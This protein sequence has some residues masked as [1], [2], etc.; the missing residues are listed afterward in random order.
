VEVMIKEGDVVGSVI[1]SYLLEKTRVVG[2]SANERNYHSFYQLLSGFADVYE[3]YEPQESP[4]E[5]LDAEYDAAAFPWETFV[6]ENGF[7]TFP[8]LSNGDRR[9]PGVD[10]GAD[11]YQLVVALKMFMPDTRIRQIMRLLTAVL[12]IGTIEFDV[13]STG[14]ASVKDTGPS[15][16]LSHT[17]ALLGV[18]TDSFSFA[19]CNRQIQTGSRASIATK[20]LGKTIPS[21]SCLWLRCDSYNENQSTVIK[22]FKMYQ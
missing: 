14:H 22:T 4:R 2:Q 11:L 9:V 5:D 19:I 15:G 17:C 7:K 18:D 1:T 10:D 8:Y 3:G 21:L 20:R 12:H 13:D 6:P 16:A